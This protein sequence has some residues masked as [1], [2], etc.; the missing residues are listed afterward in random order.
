MLVLALQF[1]RGVR[2]H[3]WIPGTLAVT[4]GLERPVTSASALPWGTPLGGVSLKTE[5]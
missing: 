4:A 5:Q 1:S 3:E 2:D